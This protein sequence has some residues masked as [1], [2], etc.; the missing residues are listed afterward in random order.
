M[1]KIKVKDDIYKALDN[2]EFLEEC[3]W[4]DGDKCGMPIIQGVKK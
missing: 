2:Q 4:L 3:Q 1:M